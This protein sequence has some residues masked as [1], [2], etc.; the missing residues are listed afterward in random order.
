MI[1]SIHFATPMSHLCSLTSLS[2][3]VS[4]S[5]IPKP[6]KW[7]PN[8][9]ICHSASRSRSASR[10]TASLS[11]LTQSRRSQPSRHRASLCLTVCVRVRVTVPHRSRLRLLRR[12]GMNRVFLFFFVMFVLVWR[13]MPAVSLVLHKIWSTSMLYSDWNVCCLC[14]LNSVFG[15]EK[16]SSLPLSVVKQCV[17]NWKIAEF[18]LTLSNFGSGMIFLL[19]CVQF[20]VYIETYAV[21]FAFVLVSRL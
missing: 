20:V 1:Q 2:L 8:F 12:G 18:P 14:Q 5:L 19:R 17:W 9:S 15:T 3:S 21:Y 11:Q 16:L 7:N 6:K 4:D 10:P 13:T